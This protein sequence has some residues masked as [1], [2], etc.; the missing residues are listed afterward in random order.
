MRRVMSIWFPRL[1]LDRWV[2]RCDPRV[3]GPFAITREIKNA[4]RITHVTQAG[5]QAGVTP[6][7]NLTDARAI[8]P[9]LMT[10]ISDPER[11]GLMLRALWRWSDKLSPWAA[12]DPPDGLYLDISGC[13]HLFGGE[14]DMSSFA[15]EQFG[16]MHIASH[17]GIADTKRAA[18]ALA[19]FAD[20]LTTIADTGQTADALKHLPLAAL[21]LASQTE[22]D[23]RRTGLKTI[24]DL[25]GRK[26]S[27]LARRFGLG[28][29]SRLSHALGH[30]PDPV[31]PQTADPV[32]AARMTLPDP[33]GLL[34]DLNIV[35]ARLA[36][37]VCKR[38]EDAQM[39]ARHFDLTIRCVDTG[40]HM[41][42]IGFARP[43]FKA[44]AVLQQFARPL[45]EL[46]LEFGA[47]WFRLVAKNLE[48]ILAGRRN[49][50]KKILTSLSRH[51]AI[52]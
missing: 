2:R 9:E 38:L 36:E 7:Q 23:L 1:P 15:H 8:C 30:A 32:Y 18:W 13:A 46:R 41:L 12:L 45:D 20:N 49:N 11:E 6:G 10:E 21:G 35:L 39:G 47:D 51:S 14:P 28:L 19:R 25:Y 33:V 24:G 5:I 50:A 26:S 17:I 44:D 40:N 48:P 52:A 27:E 16:E 42:S 3:D 37:S 29:N 34:D 43:C 4:L 31:S 22:T